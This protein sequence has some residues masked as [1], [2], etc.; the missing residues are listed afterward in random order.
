M[1]KEVLP[2]PL[3]ILLVVDSLGGGGA[4][5][6]VLLQANGLIKAG[7]RAKILNLSGIFELPVPEGVDVIDAGLS[8]PIRKAAKFVGLFEDICT[9]LEKKFGF[10]DMVFATLPMAQSL[11]YHSHRKYISIVQNTVSC[12]LLD[13]VKLR[14]RLRYKRFFRRAY[15]KNPVVC[16]SNG[17]R[18]DL[19]ERFGIPLG[20]CTV[21]H[22][23]VDVAWVSR[24]ADK[25][26]EFDSS[27]P[28]KDYILH[29]GRFCPQKRHDVLI[30]AFAQADIPGDLVLLGQ[31]PFEAEIRDLVDSMGLTQRVHFLGFK[32]NP[33]P[34]MKNARLLVLSSDFEGFG[35]VITESLACGTPVVS[36][37]CPS[38]PREILGKDMPQCL[39]PPGDIDALAQKITKIWHAPPDVDYAKVIEP[40]TMENVALKYASLININS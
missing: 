7:H 29:V 33:F 36:T 20:N 3:N 28:Q 6:A 5:R 13:I 32:E 35:C 24:M 2:K 23:P 1:R 37:D 39:C 30:R 18:D 21:I 40:F 11:L 8:F 15:K 34:Y 10:F 17:V 9:N 14:K 22:N 38:G 27:M 19:V 31:G 16:V 12:E 26:Y 25:K 4:E